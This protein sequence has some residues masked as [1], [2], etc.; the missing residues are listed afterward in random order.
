MQQR[1]N[2]RVEACCA[3]GGGDTPLVDRAKC[4][5]EVESCEVLEECRESTAG[6]VIGVLTVL[7]LVVIAC[8]I[9]KAMDLRKKRQETT[10]DTAAV[11]VVAAGEQQAPAP[12]VATCVS[13]QSIRGSHAA[14]VCID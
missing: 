4:N 2:D 7:G 8:S 9:K 13:T 1:G 14:N 10:A 6:L 5:A 12:T 11:A 3:C